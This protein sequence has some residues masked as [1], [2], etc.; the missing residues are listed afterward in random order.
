[1]TV[2]LDASVVVSLFAG[3]ANFERARRIASGSDILVISDLTAAEFASAL[4]LHMRTGRAAK[5]DVEAALERFDTWT[6][7]MVERVEVLSSDVQ[8][9]E[10]LIRRLDSALKTPDA[11]HISIARRIGATLATFDK[12]MAQESKRLGLAVATL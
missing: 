4:S 6:R 8:D 9:A 5:G 1:L 12:V 11:M 7:G 10:T 2:Y 3:D